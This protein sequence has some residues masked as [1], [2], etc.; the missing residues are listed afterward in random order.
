MKRALVALG[1]ALVATTTTAGVAAAGDDSESA[2]KVKGK[3]TL[4]NKGIPSGDPVSLVR[5]GSDE[6]ENESLK[7]DTNSKGAYAITNVPPGKYKVQL[8]TSLVPP[9]KG[10]DNNRGSSTTGGLPSIGADT[11]C[12]IKG[13]S[14]FAI[15]ARANPGTNTGSSP[16]SF[17]VV[18]A[19]QKKAFSLGAGDTKEVNI[20]IDCPSGTKIAETPASTAPPSTTP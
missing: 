10:G 6:P 7:D 20:T 1:V 3:V 11:D 4:N 12:K 14:I 9:Q 17:V 16:R 15:T 5:S 13:Y 8:T 2:G 18:Q 19:T